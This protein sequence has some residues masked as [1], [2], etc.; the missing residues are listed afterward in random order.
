M[1]MHQQ[2]KIQIRIL[3]YLIFHFAIILHLLHL[4]D[5]IPKIPPKPLFV[6]NLS[7]AQNYPSSNQTVPRIQVP[8]LHCADLQNMDV[9]YIILQCIVFLD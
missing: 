2:I 8:F 6:A 1:A 4:Q 5:E 7:L 3:L 9:L